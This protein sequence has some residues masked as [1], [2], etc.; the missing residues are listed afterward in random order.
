MKPIPP[1]APPVAEGPR[2]TCDCPTYNEGTGLFQI[3][4]QGCT[5]ASVAEGPAATP[6]CTLTTNPCGTDTVLVG[7]ECPD[8]NGYRCIPATAEPFTP[9][10]VEAR[11]A[12]WMWS[13]AEE[14]D[15][16]GHLAHNSLDQIVAVVGKHAADLQ[17]QLDEARRELGSI[18]TAAWKFDDKPHQ[19]FST[20]MAVANGSEH[21]Q[22]VVRLMDTAYNKIHDWRSAEAAN[23]ELRDK[24]S[25]AEFW[26]QWVYPEGATAE[27]VQAELAD[28]HD[29]MDRAAKVYEHITQ[30]QISKTNT[31]P[32]AVI[33][34]AD[35][36]MSKAISEAVSET[37][38]ELRS[39]L[40]CQWEANHAEHCGIWPHPD[41]DV[42]HWPKPAALLG[43]QHGDTK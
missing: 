5:V 22:E 35:D 20:I 7:Q 12:A 26:K 17:R 29:L 3:H 30:G 37:T 4:R 9:N 24:F 15:D 8:P 34:L 33:A 18:L 14:L 2:P 1:A 41:K 27:Q 40:A 31:L 36:V 28:Y 39:E 23:Q 10:A 32:E 25:A 19:L 13:A 21:E 6:R 11:A 16:E 38:E 42:C 43:P